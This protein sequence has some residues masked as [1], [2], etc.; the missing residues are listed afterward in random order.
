MLRKIVLGMGAAGVSLAMLPLLAAFEAHV[1]NVTARIENALNV[2]VREI[3]FGTVFPQEKLDQFFNV[4]L[5]Q[6]FRDEDRVD[7]VDYFIRQKPKCWNGNEQQPVFGQVTHN[8]DGTFSCVDE[9]LTILPLLCP[10]L[11]K[12]EVSEDGTAQENDEQPGIS[13]FHGPIDAS[14]WTLA[15]AKLW[16]VQ[17]HLAKAQQDFDDR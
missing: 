3:T 14:A 13:A 17:G 5:S 4:S 6:S 9:G 15:V 8:A 7:D 10:Y 16:D 1:V 12:H 2:P 11:S